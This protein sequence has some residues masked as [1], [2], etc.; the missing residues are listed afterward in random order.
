MN[1]MIVKIFYLKKEN[2]G[3]FPCQTLWYAVEAE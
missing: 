1:V 3:K 2:Y